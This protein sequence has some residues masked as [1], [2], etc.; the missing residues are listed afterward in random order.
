MR[1]IA[2]ALLLFQNCLFPITTFAVEIAS[3]IDTEVVDSTQNQ[4]ETPVSQESTP[5]ESNAPEEVI[6]APTTPAEQPEATTEEGSSAEQPLETTTETPVE[7]ATTTDSGGMPIEQG[8]NEEAPVV[9]EEVEQPVIPFV[10]N[11]LSLA[12]RIVMPATSLP[13]YSQYA[14]ELRQ[15]GQSSYVNAILRNV[16]SREVILGARIGDK[17]TFTITIPTYS[18]VD[19]DKSNG[20]VSMISSDRLNQPEAYLTRMYYGAS[21]RYSNTYSLAN[22]STFDVS[23]SIQATVVAAGMSNYTQ[24]LNVTITRTQV[25]I[26]TEASFSIK[27][28]TV[29]LGATAVSHAIATTNP[30]ERPMEDKNGKYNV[31]YQD[32]SLGTVKVSLDPEKPA[33]KP[34]VTVQAQREKDLSTDV[35]K[36]WFNVLPAG[37]TI[38]GLLYGPNQ[39]EPGK[40]GSVQVRVID[41]DGNEHRLETNYTVVDTLAPTGITKQGNFE[42][43]RFRDFT[44]EELSQLFSDLQDNWTLPE[45]ITF[46]AGRKLS[47]IAPNMGAISFEVSAID[48]AGNA[49]TLRPVAYIRDTTPPDGKLKTSL[50]YIEGS[51]EPDLRE[52]LDGD[53]TDNWTLPENIQLAIAFDSGKKFS[54]LPVGRNTFTLTLTDGNGNKKE[55]TGSLT[56]L[57]SFTIKSDVVIEAQRMMDIPSNIVKSWFEVLPENADE[58][59]YSVTSVSTTGWAPGSSGTV[60]VSVRGNGDTYSFSTRYTVVDTTPPDGKLK[61]SLIYEF[62]SAEP[63]LRELLDGN[64]TDNWTL[65]ADIKLAIAFENGKNFSE[66]PVGEHAFTLTLTDENENKKELTGSLTIRSTFTIKSKVVIE[67]QR[68]K[69]L[70]TDIIKSWFT[71]LPDD[72]DEYDYEVT[73][74]PEMWKPEDSG[75]IT[76]T[77]KN[78]KTS[79]M[80]QFTTNYSVE[81]TT[82]PDGKLKGSLEFEEGSAEPDLRELLDG[83]PTDNWSLPENIKLGITFDNDQKFS[84]LPVGDHAF[85]LILTDEMGN[86]KELKGSLTIFSKNQY[87]DVVIPAKMN[88]AQDK[89]SEGIVSPVYKIQNNSSR[90]LTVA[91]DSMTS[92]EQTERLPELTLGMQ[93][94]ELG[95]DVLLVSNGQNLSKPVELTT[96]S[97]ENNVYQFSFFGSAGPNIDLAALLVPIKPVYTMN[98]HFKIH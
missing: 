57:P 77:V 45:N 19:Q 50:S 43:N 72:A 94:K 55:L 63:D 71:T 60:S 15:Y 3:D 88:F 69:E 85:T 61:D 81:D 62:G 14:A 17:Q 11:N 8:G 25:P 37:S 40:T 89:S 30:Y 51:E 64:P 7:A 36:S 49:L 13:N 91:V 39:W 80:Q 4:E 66:Q 58:Y 90:A 79:D 73:S 24:T 98:L 33:L 76:V 65:S 6:G 35:L 47:D 84:E 44:Q 59:T 53:P 93:N 38:V 27:I 54:E 95:Q 22:I 86:K 26:D 74:G 18:Y 28:G 48:E 1:I 20:W 52:L 9:P 75:E 92:V 31:T 46:K 97:Q 83:D 2:T 34:S 68:S 21:P 5:S 23:P 10:G 87:I 70:T 12:P 78:K 16:A 29:T 41:K 42:A 32:V 56:I 67:A 96:L 82:P